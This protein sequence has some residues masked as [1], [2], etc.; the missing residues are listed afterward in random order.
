[1][2]ELKLKIEGAAD[3]TRPGTTLGAAPFGERGSG[4]GRGRCVE[5]SDSD[6]VLVSFRFP[7]E[8]NDEL[9]KCA[10]E[11]GL[12]KTAYLILALRA[13]FGHEQIRPET[14]TN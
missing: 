10:K 1:M 6:R 5:K 3:E 8:V 12:N 11:I 9:E 14:R 4:G 2:I 7:R 13:F